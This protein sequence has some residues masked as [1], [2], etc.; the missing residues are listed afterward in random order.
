M[1]C[2]HKAC[3]THYLAYLQFIQ[4][5]LTMQFTL[6]EILKFEHECCLSTV[7][8]RTSPELR[9]ELYLRKFHDLKFRQTFVNAKK[10]YPGMPEIDNALYNVYIRWEKEK[11]Q[12][13]WTPKNYIDF[14]NRVRKAAQPHLR[15]K[16]LTSACLKAA[17]EAYIMMDEFPIEFGESEWKEMLD[18]MINKY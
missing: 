4:L 10:V 14:Y 11:L 7:K 18:K 12:G 3:F 13:G 17:Y 15:G 16:L 2:T 6:E 8:W 9:E 1:V 5:S